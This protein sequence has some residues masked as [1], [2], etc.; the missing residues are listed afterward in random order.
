MQNMIE[1][2]ALPSDSLYLNIF[3]QPLESVQVFKKKVHE[4]N[5]RNNNNR[6]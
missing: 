1:V 4:I 3:I 5:S 6:I 2:F